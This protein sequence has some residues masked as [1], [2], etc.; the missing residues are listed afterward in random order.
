LTEEESQ[1]AK[2]GILPA[3]VPPPD[4]DGDGIGDDADNCRF[5]FNQRQQDRDVD[6]VGDACDN[7]P[8]VYNPGQEDGDVD[9]A[10]DAC[11]CNPTNPSIGSCEDN[12]TCSDDICDPQLGCTHAFNANTCDDLN[13]CTSNDTCGNGACVGVPVICNDQNPC[14]N[15]FCQPLSSQC[16]ACRYQPVPPGGACGNPSS[17]PC[18]NADS[19]DA[20]GTCQSNQVPNG[21]SCNDGNGCTAGEACSGGSCVGGSPVPPPPE[22]QGVL[23]GSDKAT[24]SWIPTPGATRYDVV[25]GMTNAY[26]VGPGTLDELCFDDLPGPSLVDGTVPGPGTG[27]WY[28]SRAEN[29]CGN[30]TY[31][32]Q[33]VNGAPG[34][35]RTTTTCP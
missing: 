21:T 4:S 8:T 19:C 5:I 35:T 25:R 23:V 15:D 28:L 17:G 27:L 1:L 13:P 26:P 2:H 3:Q 16:S 22:A 18:D 11:D 31:G 14:T 29:P 34:A 33:G 12:N 24:Y 20:Q 30:G 9:G 32:T 7:C 10:G 6:G